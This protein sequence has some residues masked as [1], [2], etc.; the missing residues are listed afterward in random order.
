[1]RFPRVILAVA[2]LFV[3]A[4]LA[5]AADA[6]LPLLSAH[7]TVE[8]VGKDTLTIRPRGPDGRF[9]TSLTLKVTG[10]SEIATLSTRMSMKKLVIAQRKTELKSLKPKQAIAVLYTTVK[11]NPVL[12]TAVAQPAGK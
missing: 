5:S 11:D 9:G 2:L 3:L 7:G 6:P 4:G 1:M 12:L 10:T 8:K